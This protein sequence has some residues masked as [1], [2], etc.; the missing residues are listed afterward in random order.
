VVDKKDIFICHTSEDKEDYI[1]PFCRELERQGID[2]WIDE[3]QIQGGMIA[4]S[5]NDG[6]RISTFVLAFISDNFIGKRWPETELFSALYEQIS[7]HKTRILVIMIADRKTI[8]NYY[9]L[10]QGY[11]YFA[12]WNE[13]IPKIVS[14][15]KNRLEQYNNEFATTCDKTES[16]SV[17]KCEI[18]FGVSEGEEEGV[19]VHTLIDDMV[20]SASMIRGPVNTGRP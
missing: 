16:P 12:N 4:K 11:G 1:F 9:P 18:D 10:L 7:T 8:D 17:E 6:L 2:Y 15:L 20:P 3:G 19:T 5:I 14:R 13:G